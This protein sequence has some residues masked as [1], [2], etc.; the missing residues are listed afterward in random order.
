MLNYEESITKAKDGVMVE[1]INIGEGV[2]GDYNENDPED[3][4]LLRFDIY[5]NESHTSNANESGWES[6]DS[7]CTMLPATMDNT[8]ITRAL[9]MLFDEFYN[10]LKNDH[11][12][13]IRRL[14]DTLSWIS[15]EDI[16]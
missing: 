1:I 14:G 7:W 3:I 9:N 8:K 16:L 11:T 2:Q 13:S 10:A 4:N 15:E 5:T 12:V 6:V